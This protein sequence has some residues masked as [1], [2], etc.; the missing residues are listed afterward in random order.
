MAPTQKQWAKS[1]G[2]SFFGSGTLGRARLAPSWTKSWLLPALSP[3]EPLPL[4]SPP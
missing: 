1:E 4:I 2:F 3:D